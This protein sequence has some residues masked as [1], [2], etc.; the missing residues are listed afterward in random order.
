MLG[1]S[2]RRRVILH[3]MHTSENFGDVLLTKILSKQ[4]GDA[5]VALLRSSLDVASAVGLQRAG[6]I[7]LLRCSH[8][9]LGGGDIFRELTVLEERSA[10][11]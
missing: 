6:V 1:K 11:S 8:V 4:I 5:H 3:G 2:D 7:D 10:R 9:I